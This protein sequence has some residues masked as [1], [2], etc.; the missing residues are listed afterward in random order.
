MQHLFDEAQRAVADV[1]N[2]TDSL[3]ETNDELRNELKQAFQEKRAA[4]RL[5]A[6]AKRLAANWLEKWHKEREQ[7]HEVEDKLAQ[8]EK[9]AK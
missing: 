7:R 3:E 1:K 9:A 6:K 4:M 8:Q 5:T 2:Y